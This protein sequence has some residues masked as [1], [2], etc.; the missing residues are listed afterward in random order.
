MSIEVKIVKEERLSAN[1]FVVAAKS[2]RSNIERVVFVPPK[3]GDGTF[4]EFLVTYKFSKLK[5][6]NG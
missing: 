2:D 3:I 4:G 1:Q 5:R 6:S